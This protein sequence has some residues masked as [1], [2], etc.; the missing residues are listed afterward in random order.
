MIRIYSISV[1][2]A[3]ILYLLAGLR[4]ES[5]DAGFDLD[6]FARLPVVADGRIKPMDTVART[7]LLTLQGRQRFKTEAPTEI[8]RTPTE[9]LLD[10]FYRAEL[11]DDY[12]HFEIVHPG[13][14]DVLG[15]T[16]EDGDGK[17]RFSYNQMADHL[18]EL[19]RQAT[20]AQGIEAPA[21]DVFQ[22]AVLQTRNR[23]IAYQQLKHS[24]VVPDGRN[25][26]SQLQQLQ[27][28][29]PAGVEAVRA[30]SSDA[31]HDDALANR[32]IDAGQ[33]F[34]QLDQYAAMLPLPPLGEDKSDLA[35]QKTGR[36][37]LGAFQ[38]GMVNPYAL[39]Y[40]AMGQ[41]WR[42]QD[43]E[44]FNKLVELYSAQLQGDFGDRLRKTSIEA[45]FNQ[46][47]P[48]YRSSVL[49]VV[50]FLMAII[51]WLVW[52]RPLQKYGAQLV[53]LAW[54]ATTIGI[55]IRMWLEGRP[56]V[57]NL[58]SSA[59]FVGW[60]AVGLCLILE[61]IYRNGIGTTAGGLIGFGTLLIAHHL[62][63][64]GDT[65][66]MMRAVLDSN[67]WLAT[68]VIIIT[69]GYSATFLAGFLALIYVVRGVFTKSLDKATADALSRMVY[70]IVCFAT[71]FSLVGTILGGIWAD[72]SWGR[73]WGWDPKEN[74]A[75][76]IVIWNAIVLHARWGGIARTRGIMALAVFGN[77][78]TSWSWFGTNML[79]VGL[80]SYGF[81]DAAF[82]SLVAFVLSQLVLIAVAYV[83]AAKWRSADRLA[84]G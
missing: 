58:Y 68:H 74:G 72:Q 22:R 5:S 39:T 52:T 8:K 18:E 10:V 2:A 34:M 65:L 62:S 54:V 9:W 49:Y 31:D 75:L 70:G 60:G 43:A 23:I 53:A 37:L 7:H 41:A 26:L 25:F 11:A 12:R 84:R 20:M 64:Q 81:M 3:G 33:A 6:G 38:T 40:A 55:A 73:F 17:K 36:A 24:L 45:T 1:L 35:W 61:R 42:D 56:P 30:R 83:P 44:T 16:P 66:E 29:L 57:T 67:F 48:F 28:E 79:G 21:R 71:L 78:V 19:D 76:L 59:L 51:S 14:L 63:L 13:V 46:A 77:I 80:H 82:W 27:D 47:E 15:L 69:I 50:A 4:P 32:M